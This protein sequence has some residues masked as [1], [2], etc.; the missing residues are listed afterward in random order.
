VCVALQ[1]KGNQVT[2][3]GQ[4]KAFRSGIKIESA[5]N[6][7]TFVWKKAVTKNQQKL[8]DKI[9]KLFQEVDELFGIKIVYGKLI[10]QYHMKKLR[11]KLKKIQVAEN[12]TFVRGSGK[13]KSLVQKKLE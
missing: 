7:Y 12:I 1:H 11:K 2:K 5:P 9:P 3:T 13:R 4:K 10:K 6:K 8:I